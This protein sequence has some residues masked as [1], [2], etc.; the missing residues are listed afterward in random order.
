MG[1]FIC[2]NGHFRFYGMGA[3]NNISKKRDI[4]DILYSISRK[5]LL[6]NCLFRYMFDFW[7]VNYCNM[8]S[9]FDFVDNQKILCDIKNSGISS[10]PIPAMGMFC[11][12]PKFEYLL[13]ELILHENKKVNMPKRHITES[14]TTLKK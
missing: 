13:F 1:Y 7:R 8:P 10:C 14:V 6:V 5:Y 12:Y 2:I 9:M 4:T 3:H 11:N